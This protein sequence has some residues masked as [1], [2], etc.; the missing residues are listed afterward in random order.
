MQEASPDAPYNGIRVYFDFK[1]ARPWRPP[2]K[3]RK[4]TPASAS[5]WAEYHLAMTVIRKEFRAVVNMCVF[6]RAG[7]ATNA[8]RLLVLNAANRRPTSAKLFLVGAV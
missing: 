2:S 5:E 8:S 1:C 6:G 4:R 3:K 7:A